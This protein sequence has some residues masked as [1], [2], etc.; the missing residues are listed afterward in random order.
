MS[1]DGNSSLPQ[2]TSG[3]AAIVNGPPQAACPVCGS[4]LGEKRPAAGDSGVLRAL[5]SEEK[6]LK[7]APLPPR[8]TT[9]WQQFD[10]LLVFATFL[11]FACLY[12][13]WLP[14][15][16]GPIQGWKVY[17]STP[18]MTLDELRHW[19]MVERPESLYSILVAG[20]IGLL[21]CRTSRHVGVRDLVASVLLVA[22]GGYLLTYFAHEWGWCLLYYYVG[23]YAAFLALA[24]LVVAGLLRTKFM[25]WIGQSQVFRLLASAFLLTGFFLPWSL[26][27]SGV[28]LMLVAQN[29]YWLGIPRV[30]AYLM[31]VFPALGF[32]S[33]VTAFRNVPRKTNLFVRLWP[34]ILGSA[35]LVYFHTAWTPYLAGFPL[36]SWGT[37][38][39]LTIL[40]ASGL[41]EIKPSKPAV[42]QLLMWAF[43]VV[44]VV[45]WLAVFR[46]GLED[47]FSGFALLPPLMGS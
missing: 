25:P 17:Y 36:G 3:E 12:L 4:P 13:P 21:F 38:G 42:G 16:Y 5:P 41:L 31:S 26:D 47:L 24:L 37:L 1:S 23:P 35:A 11:A 8:E 29:F 7:P 34:L 46:G 28:H 39:G 40:T 22:G 33:F 45:F 2:N 44:S 32:V 20:F 19:E 6:R 10:R 15:L 43:L 18:D 27:Q 30:Y 9:L 14:G